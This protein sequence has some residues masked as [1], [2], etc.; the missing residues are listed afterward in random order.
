MG[1][2]D[3]LIFPILD[4]HFGMVYPASGEIPNRGL[5]EN[6]KV[7]QQKANCFLFEGRIKLRL[8]VICEEP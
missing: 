2:V 1:L 5:N 3:A 8:H 6:R 4:C 7:P